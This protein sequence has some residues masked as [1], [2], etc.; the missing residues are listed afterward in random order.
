M[1]I[2]TP[3]WFRMIWHNTAST[4]FHI[5][6]NRIWK[7]Y[8]EVS[9]GREVESE[10]RMKIFPIWGFLLLRT[11]LGKVQPKHIWECSQSCHGSNQLLWRRDETNSV[12][13]QTFQ[14]Q[15]MDK[16]IHCYNMARLNGKTKA[17]TINQILRLETSR[18]DYK[19]PLSQGYSKYKIL[20]DVIKWESFYSSVR[21]INSPS[22]TILN[23]KSQMIREVIFSL[24]FKVHFAF[25]S[26]VLCDLCLIKTLH[27]EKKKKIKKIF[28][29]LVMEW[30]RSL[31]FLNYISVP[32]LDLNEYHKT[33]FGVYF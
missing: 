29:N 13:K 16:M 23:S 32:K 28:K 24:P 14:L 19:M 8:P 10:E 22:F 21:V 15:L 31:W 26:R 3:L 12:H 25:P 18:C 2:A 6:R 27:S 4:W 7:R 9:W 17:E 20:L 1:Y 11:A 33:V 30:R 5:H